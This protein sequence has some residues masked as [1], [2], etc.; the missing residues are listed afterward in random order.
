M[1]TE[2][3]ANDAA[4]TVPLAADAPASGTPETWTVTS[5]SSFPAATTSITKFHVADP[6]APSEVILVTNVSGTSWSV[7]RGAESTTPVTHAA[8]FTVV[9]VIPA[10]WLGNTS[11]GFTWA[12]TANGM[13]CDGTTDDTSALNALLTVVSNAGGGTVTFPSLA[14]ISGQIVLPTSVSSGQLRQAPIRLQGTM[15]NRP[16]ETEIGVAYSTGG[17]DLRYAGRT[18]TGCG[19]TLGSN[20]VTDASAVSGDYGQIIISPGNLPDRTCIMAVTPGVGYSLNNGARATNASAS[21]TI[22]GG[23]IETHGIGTLELDHMLI[24][25]QGTSAQPF[26]LS[27]GTTVHMHDC[28]VLGNTSKASGTCNQDIFV[29]GGPGQG[30]ALTSALVSGSVYTSLAVTALPVALL[31]SGAALTIAIANGT[32]TQQVACSAA[33]V[34]ATSITTV[35]FTANANYGIGSAVVFAGQ[36][37]AQGATA[38][39]VPAAPFQ[40]YG[41][42]L[43]DNFFDR[44]RRTLIQTWASDVYLDTNVWWQNCGSNLAVTPSTLTSGLTL[45]TGY[46]SLT[47]SA[48]AAAVNTGDQ[49]ELISGNFGLTNT[50]VATAS[51]PAAASATTISVNS[52]TANFSYPTTTRVFNSTAGIGAAVEVYGVAA[53]VSQVNATSNRVELSGAYSYAF[54]IGGTGAF[55]SVLVGNNLQDANAANIA[56]YRFDPGCTYNLVIPGLTAN[57]AVPMLDDQSIVATYGGGQ[58]VL[59]SQQSQPANL[60]Q[61]LTTRGQL[62]IMT[63]GNL[64]YVFD[65]SGNMWQHVMTTSSWFM[66]YTPAGGSVQPVARFISN[67]G[68]SVTW[69]VESAI[70]TLLIN[71]PGTV[72]LRSGAGSPLNFGDPTRQTDVYVENGNLMVTHLLAQGTAPTVAAASSSTGLSIAGQDT[73]HNV[74]LTTAASIGAGSSVATITFGLSYTTRGPNTTPRFVL[75]PKTQASAT[76][77]AYITGDSVTAYSI[78][79]ANPPGGATAMAF[80]VHVVGS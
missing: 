11:L 19:T 70:T 14:K 49:I 24:C 58:V 34:G 41:T 17:L 54:R 57:S 43:H 73:A 71:G 72:N 40:G 36:Q 35:S 29:A 16:G 62:S 4:T 77:Q 5:S 38:Y 56:S 78:A 1:A 60:P 75:T 26:I 61:G 25:D 20:I 7:T 37:S 63:D 59:K 15:P 23:K 53:N 2:V 8:G 22:G 32:N 47:V 68:T 45:G 3:F 64:P 44:V 21:F 12:A 50:Q 74:A 69:T 55:E 66:H 48:L 52:F 31:S 42:H 76:A 80:D 39:A 27:T 30:A 28:A 10:G 9:Q 65:I 13:A 51:A 18:D 79:L 67:S 6:A 33:A 46:T